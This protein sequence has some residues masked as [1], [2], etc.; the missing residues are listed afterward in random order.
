V[1]TTTVLVLRP[2]CCARAHHA[3]PLSPTVFE[4]ASDLTAGALSEALRLERLANKAAVRKL[5]L[6]QQQQQQQKQQE[7][8][9]ASASAET[10]GGATAARGKFQ[11]ASKATLSMAAPAAKPP[12]STSLSVAVVWKL[13]AKQALLVRQLAEFMRSR[14]GVG[15]AAKMSRLSQDGMNV[16]VP[17]PQEAHLIRDASTMTALEFAKLALNSNGITLEGNSNPLDVHF[18]KGCK[19]LR[20][21][22]AADSTLCEAINEI[23]ASIESPP[24]AAAASATSG[25]MVTANLQNAQ[26]QNVSGADLVLALVCDSPLCAC[27]PPLLLR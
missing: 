10:G 18:P 22:L 25:S 23:A 1:S 17:M 8:G 7:R 15:V 9:A 27:P 4:P 26:R 3:P 19:F 2:V 14:A 24:A 21:A 11:A 20:A 13:S 16:P 5:Q 6:L 12:S